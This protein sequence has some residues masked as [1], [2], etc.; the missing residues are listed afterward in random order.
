MKQELEFLFCESHL[1]TLLEKSMDIIKKGF[2]V[3]VSSV[4]NN[5]NFLCYVLFNKGPT[6]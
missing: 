5:F 6:M 4:K 2:H 3:G 1:Y